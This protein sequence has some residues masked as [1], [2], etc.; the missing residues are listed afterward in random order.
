MAVSQPNVWKVALSITRFPS[1][2]L[3]FTHMRSI[4]PQ[5]SLPTVPTASASSSSP[6]F[7]GC[8]IASSILLLKS[9][10]AFIHLL[11]IVPGQIRINFDAP[12]IDATRHRPNMLNAVTREERGCIQAPDAA[13]ANKDEF[14]VL[15]RF[16]NDF[17]HQFLSEKRGTL[18]VNG[19]PLL[20]AANINQ[21]ELF[22]CLQPLRDLCG[23]DLH[24]LICFV[25]DQDCTDYFL[26]REIVVSRTNRGQSFAGTK[27]AARTA[28]NVVGPEKSSLSTGALLKKLCHRHIQVNC[29][30]HAHDRQRYIISSENQ[31][32]RL[33]GPT[34][35]AQRSRILRWTH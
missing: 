16:G 26:D 14:S 13:V 29:S 1:T 19:V 28:P 9:S 12:G 25:P 22:T 27:A 10:L 11:Q 5:S 7:F 31:R 23:R 3:N 8:L 17:L 32:G 15:R 6:R 34:A 21:W 35:T 18:D 20:S 2:S 4:S 33:A 24:L 30:R